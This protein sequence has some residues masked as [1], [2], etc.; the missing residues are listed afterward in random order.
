[1]TRHLSIGLLLSYRL[2]SGTASPASKR[3][4]FGL[5][6]EPW[7][8]PHSPI[9]SENSSRHALGYF[10]V[11]YF[12]DHTRWLVSALFRPMM[13]DSHVCKAI[14]PM[15]HLRLGTLLQGKQEAPGSAAL[16][17]PRLQS[18]RLDAI[19]TLTRVRFHCD[20]ESQPG[21]TLATA[22]SWPAA[23]VQDCGS[24]LLAAC[25]SSCGR[26]W[27]ALQLSI[28]IQHAPGFHSAGAS[29]ACAQI[30]PSASRSSSTSAC[31]ASAAAPD[32]AAGPTRPRAPCEPP[33]DKEHFH[34][35]PGNRCVSDR[36]GL[37]SPSVRR[38]TATSARMAAV[39]APDPAAGPRPLRAAC[40]ANINN[41][42]IHRSF[43][44]MSHSGFTLS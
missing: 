40:R 31:T 29:G 42:T 21:G 37:C 9:A 26:V 8:C 12:G 2:D 38:S 18:W 6:H 3:T 44:C 17:A 33:E 5:R 7:Q 43:R 39:A 36:E 22:V 25:Q 10:L 30:S 4:R 19:D 41:A 23:A 34:S 24:D 14:S 13:Q 20:P 28:V 35:R 11:Q 15:P 1:M 16:P 32:P 27:A